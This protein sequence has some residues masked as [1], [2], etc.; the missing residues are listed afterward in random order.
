M[1]VLRP[2]GIVFIDSTLSQTEAVSVVSC[3]HVL[4]AS[5]FPQ[6]P[7]TTN[8]TTGNR[9]PPWVKKINTGGPGLQA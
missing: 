9:R 7:Y 2:T 6:A 4:H 1:T 3:H 8:P 5:V